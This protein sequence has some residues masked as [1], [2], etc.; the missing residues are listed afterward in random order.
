MT[1]PTPLKIFS[2]IEKKNHNGFHVIGFIVAATLEAEF[3]IKNGSES[4][5]AQRGGTDLWAF[6]S[7]PVMSSSCSQQSDQIH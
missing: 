5:S 7:C 1:F 2:E 4:V 3:C 6:K